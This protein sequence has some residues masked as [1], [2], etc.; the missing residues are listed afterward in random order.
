MPGG[1]GT[2][3]AADAA[4]EPPEAARQAFDARTGLPALAADR[5]A[6]A[7]LAAATRESAA[8]RSALGSCAPIVRRL[9]ALL[10]W[11]ADGLRWVSAAPGAA[12]ARRARDAEL[13]ETVRVVRNLAAATGDGSEAAGAITDTLIES[14]VLTVLLDLAMEDEEED[15]VRPGGAAH[16]VSTLALQALANL[17]L[18]SAAARALLWQISF[19]DRLL[20]VVRKRRRP[21]DGRGAPGG[22]GAPPA[23]AWR[24]V[25][26]LNTIVF[27]VVRRDRQE[28]ARYAL[29]GAG[30]EITSRSIA[31]LEDGGQG[32]P[33]LV[34]VQRVLMRCAVHHGLIGRMFAF[35]GCEE[36]MAGLAGAEGD[37]DA[38]LLAPRTS[39][40]PSSAPSDALASMAL[41][42]G[43][44]QRL[45]AMQG[46]EPRPRRRPGGPQPGGARS[47]V[48]RLRDA[49]DTGNKIH[50]SGRYTLSQLRV[51]EMVFEGLQAARCAPHECH[52]APSRAIARIGG[53][54]GSR[55]RARELTIVRASASASDSAPRP[56]STREHGAL[57]QMGNNVSARELESIQEA[58]RAELSVWSAVPGAAD[59]AFEAAER[60]AA[61]ERASASPG[62]AAGG[63]GVADVAILE[64]ALRTVRELSGMG[65]GEEASDGAHVRVVRQLILMLSALPSIH[66]AI[67][68]LR[69]GPAGAAPSP[70][71]SG[72]GGPSADAAQGGGCQH[73]FPSVNPYVGYRSDVIGAI[74]NMV[75]RRRQLQDAVRLTDA[76]G[77]Y[78]GANG[79]GVVL[80]HCAPDE[81]R[82]PAGADPNGSAAG[83]KVNNPFLREWAL[84]CVRNL[85]EGNLEN[86]D[87]IRRLEVLEAA[88][89]QT[90][91]DLGLEVKLNERTKR[92]EVVAAGRGRD[93]GGAPPAAGRPPR[94]TVTE[95]SLE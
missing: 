60:I 92:P 85:T 51:L 5:Y 84:F 86:Q 57:M 32:A 65:E 4:A 42:G 83:P 81:S 49:R 17:C 66:G 33:A 22:A 14:G 52:I 70:H 88:E 47:I 62:T 6:V 1:R 13:T 61:A 63:D 35:I 28:A 50:M 87:A 36:R 55:A 24:W 69:R 21:A 71:A 77:A 91:K 12:A 10:R 48:S 54:E 29:S 30:C 16:A 15:E 27:S 39:A 76:I 82:A 2:A 26:P 59:I 68:E 38:S 18:G 25:A 94:V 19:P 8:V 74:G 40:A 37:D 43:P 79:L 9:A 53:V 41:A 56:I 44:A 58:N 89:N 31:E 80:S 45:S 23:A 93:D 67:S 73:R 90:M 20:A 11:L 64:L 75:Y 78:E 72:A 7:D 95:S 46:M 34:W 3:D